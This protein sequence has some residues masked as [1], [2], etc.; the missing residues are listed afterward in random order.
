M[1]CDLLPEGQGIGIIMGMTP[2]SPKAI[3][4]YSFAHE[5]LKKSTFKS[6]I[7]TLALFFSLILP[8]CTAQKAHFWLKMI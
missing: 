5:N 3:L 6:S 8:A 1:Y 4:L 2:T 7:R